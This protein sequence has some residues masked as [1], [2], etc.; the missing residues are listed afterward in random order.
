MTRGYV[1]AVILGLVALVGCTQAPPPAVDTRDTDAKAIKDAEMA[2]NKDWAAKDLDK[3]VGHYA[4]DASVEIPNVPLMTGKAAIT[5]GLKPLIGDPNLAL[6][7]EAAQVEVSKSGDLAY[8]RGSYSM[9]VTDEKTKKPIVEKGKFVTVYR[10]MADGSWK[11]VQDINNA[12]AP[13]APVK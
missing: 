13:A 11:A 10:K 3:I 4:D 6:T 2:W 8:T 7:F 12:D 9:T 5:G 1:V